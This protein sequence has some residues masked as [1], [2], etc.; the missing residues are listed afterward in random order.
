M[1]CIQHQ[2]KRFL[3]V[4]AKLPNNLSNPIFNE[5]DANKFLAKYTVT[6][7]KSRN[8]PKLDEIKEVPIPYTSSDYIS[9]KENLH[10]IF[11]SE[12]ISRDFPA[13]LLISKSYLLDNKLEKPFENYSKIDNL[14]QTGNNEHFNLLG[15]TY[16]N[17]LAKKYSTTTLNF[18]KLHGKEST[19]VLGFLY[20]INY[21]NNNLTSLEKALIEKLV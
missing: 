21:K 15:D 3:K 5:T 1:F 14:Q 2:S 9:L 16:A 7:L 12:I 20:L 4:K 8:L 11:G 13:N 18:K 17:F 19:A 6:G 10:A